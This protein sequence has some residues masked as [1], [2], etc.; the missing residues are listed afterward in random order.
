MNNITDFD[1]KKAF[2]FIHYGQLPPILI[3]EYWN[4]Y[5]KI[6]NIENEYLEFSEKYKMDGFKNYNDFENKFNDT[7]QKCSKLFLKKSLNDTINCLMKHCDG[8]DE[9]WM[10]HFTNPPSGN[11]I[12][13][14]DIHC[15][16]ETLLKRLNL[17]ND[18]YESG[19]D[20]IDKISQFETF[21]NYKT[22][23]ICMIRLAGLHQ[24]KYLFALISNIL[25][26]EIYESDDNVIKMLNS[27]Y[28]VGKTI[29]DSLVYIT[30]NDNLDKISGEYTYKDM[31]YHID[32]FDV[33]NMEI[34]GSEYL[35][36]WTSPNQLNTYRIPQ[37]FI[38]ITNCILNG[39]IPTKYDLAIGYEDQIFF[40]LDEND[41][42]II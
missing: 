25:L 3:D 2:T 26:K 20:I 18:D 31:N 42:K 5:M 23:R 29:C 6:F 38:P 12:V 16:G 19:Y 40:Y 28:P 8:L 13:K 22:I 34:L 27:K 30:G 24:N 37:M 4:H 21:K 35:N 7:V 11:N 17:F 15:A 1:I 33:N 14:V 9:T 36:L 32:I 10:P 39:R 41:Y